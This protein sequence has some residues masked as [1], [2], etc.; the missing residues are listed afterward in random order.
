MRAK[1]TTAQGAGGAAACKRSA[2]YLATLSFRAL[3]P[4]HTVHGMPAAAAPLA[5]AKPECWD[6]MGMPVFLPRICRTS[7]RYC[8]SSTLLRCLHVCYVSALSQWAVGV[9]VESKP[10]K[11]GWSLHEPASRTARPIT[12]L[13]NILGARQC[14]RLGAH[15]Q[16]SVSPI[17]DLKSFS[18][19]ATPVLVATSTP[20]GR[21]LPAVVSHLIIHLS[22]TQLNAYG[23]TS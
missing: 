19:G 12:R 3:S 6:G 23:T 21:T 5:E 7:S 20:S 9:H 16:A 18:C 2:K 15:D 1:T 10:P 4:P 17:F 22:A 13:A 14:G 8:R 11:I